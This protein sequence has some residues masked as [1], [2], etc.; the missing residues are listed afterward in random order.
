M[1]QIL[2][3][4][5]QFRGLVNPFCPFIQYVYCLLSIDYWFHAIG[6]QPLHSGY[7]LLQV[8]NQH[9]PVRFMLMHIRR[10]LTLVRSW[11]TLVRSYLMYTRLHHMQADVYAC[12]ACFLPFADRLLVPCNQ[13]T[14]PCTLVIA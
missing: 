12:T 14:A 9:S 6:S 11:F 5:I 4:L 8:E 1:N 7:T 13:V 10:K 3:P 2:V